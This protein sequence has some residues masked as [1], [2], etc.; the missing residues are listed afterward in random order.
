MAIIR[1]ARGGGPNKKTDD[2]TKVAAVI[3]TKK[4]QI[5]KKKAVAKKPIADK[6][7]T[8]VKKAVA[9]PKS[10]AKKKAPAKPKLL[11]P[12]KTL[13]TEA[14]WK[15]YL[16]GVSIEQVSEYLEKTTPDSIDVTMALALRQ[17]AN[18][19]I[20]ATE[21]QP[22]GFNQWLDYFSDMT[23]G[24][25]EL[26]I[27]THRESL[28]NEA[29][30]AGMRWLQIAENPALIDKIVNSR[31]ESRKAEELGDIMTAAK[32]GDDLV[33]YEAIRNN[34]AY[35]IQEGS[36]ARDMSVLIKQLNEVTTHL[37]AIYRERGMKD[38]QQSNI[39]KL[40]V[41][42]RQRARRPKQQA[43]MTINDY[44]DGDVESP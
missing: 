17:I 39:R 37:N 43:T 41:N 6:E 21:K 40:L 11:S 4:K 42:A 5:E 16:G 7:K 32:S 38:D 14:Q 20:K 27:E 19:L 1:P 18:K 3:D 2:V 31:L 12:P 30:A 23:R 34:I 22:D 15:K 13:K 33:L 35:K 44:E 24:E 36:G 10:K 28:D 25:T 26:F 9:K 8:P 29:M